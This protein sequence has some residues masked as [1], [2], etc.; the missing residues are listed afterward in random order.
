MIPWFYDYNPHQSIADAQHCS[1]LPRLRSE[2][3][4]DHQIPTSLTSTPK[5]RYQRS[6]G[7]PPPPK[8]IHPIS[9]CGFVRIQNEPRTQHLSFRGRRVGSNTALPPRR[10]EFLGTLTSRYSSCCSVRQPKPRQPWGRGSHGAP[11]LLGCFPCPRQLLR[12]WGRRRMARQQVWQ[13]LGRICLQSNRLH[14][15]LQ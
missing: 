4:W 5:S 15:T 14:K 11:G 12:S 13:F 3:T 9:R 6:A 8:K 2:P 1:S 10:R 7:F